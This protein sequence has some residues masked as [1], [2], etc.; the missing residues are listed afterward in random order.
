M[1]AAHRDRH[2]VADDDLI[3]I[4]DHRKFRDF[5]NSENETLR[6]VNHRAERIGDRPFRRL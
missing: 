4:V 2:A 5:P 1:I 3:A 6:R